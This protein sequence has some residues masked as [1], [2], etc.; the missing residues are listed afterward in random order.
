[1]NGMNEN[2]RNSL[3]QSIKDFLNSASAVEPC[4]GDPMQFLDVT[5]WLYGTDER[6]NVRL[7]RHHSENAPH[8][9]RL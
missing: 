4:L 5:F 7:P 8:N 1:M 6:W 2:G 9:G 3:I